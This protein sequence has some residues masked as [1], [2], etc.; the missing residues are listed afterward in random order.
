VHAVAGWDGRL[1]SAAASRG[2]RAVIYFERWQDNVLPSPAGRWPPWLEKQVRS[3]VA[4]PAW[5]SHDDA[6]ALAAQLGRI[7][8]FQS[9]NSED[10]LTWSWFGTLSCGSPEERRATLGWLYERVAIDASPSSEAVIDQWPRVLHPNAR[11]SPRGPEI[12]ARINDPS[13]AVIYVEAKWE[14]DLGTGKGAVAGE[15]DDQL[16]LRRDSLGKDP[17]FDDGGRPLVVLG[18]SREIHDV[19]GYEL[20]DG[21]HRVFVRGLTWA[22]LANC[23]THPLAY[24]FRRYLAWRSS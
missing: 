1:V 12:D 16:V 19:A 7:S 23:S 20:I 15:R 2:Q 14:A 3:Y 11:D 5:F 21:R 10:A 18:V 6:I 17:A 13:G 4:R 9:A 24:E 22:D 8:K